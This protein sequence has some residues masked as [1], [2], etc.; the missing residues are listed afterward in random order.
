MPVSA[1]NTPNA[2]ASSTPVA[3]LA[4]LTISAPGSPPLYVVN[5]AEAIVSRGIT[6]EPYPFQVTLPMDDSDTLPQV[7][8]AI[9]N[10]DSAIIEFIR[11]LIDPPS[12]AIELVTSA[13]PDLVEKSLTFLKLVSVDYDV[14]TIN[15]RL[16]VDDFLTQRFPAEGYVPPLFPGLFR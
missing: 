10:L 6:F 5:N 7:T 8:L 12:I 15:G 2:L 1:Y 9:S 11:R 14:L 4:L 13:Y 3:W 16:D